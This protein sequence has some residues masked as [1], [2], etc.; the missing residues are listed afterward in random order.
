MTPKHSYTTNQS[1][2]ML[3]LV[4]LMTLLNGTGSTDNRQVLTTILTLVNEV[5]TRD[6]ERL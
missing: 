2:L 1:G 4:T 5:V 3:T 6:S